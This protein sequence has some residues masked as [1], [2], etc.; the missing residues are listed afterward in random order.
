MER[1]PLDRLLRFALAATAVRWVLTGLFA[2]SLAV[3][4]FSQTLHFAGFGL[5]HAV[6]VVLIHRWFRG[7]LQG[8]GQA[9]YSS[10]GFGL[11]GALGSLYSGYAWSGAGPTATYLIA[12]IL[13]AAGWAIARGGLETREKSH[14]M[15]TDH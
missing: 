3:L 7:R 14:T 15:S 12:A 11:G 10:I 8:R 4:V 13:A 2:D 9:L 5:F 6:A 1:Y